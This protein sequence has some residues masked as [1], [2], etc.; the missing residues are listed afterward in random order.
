MALEAGCFGP[1]LSTGTWQE[2]M[3][4]QL[5]EATMQLRKFCK[6]QKLACYIQPFKTC[7]LSLSTL[8]STPYLKAKAHRQ[9]IVSLW[10]ETVMQR[11]TTLS[12]STEATM[13]HMCIDGF[14]KSWQICKAVK[15]RGS[16][17]LEGNESEQLDQ[18]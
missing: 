4:P 11:C 3:L 9:A 18:A 8:S 7:T 6:E 16:I 5:R 2:R 12:P 13:A 15:A 10:L 14:N 17:F 1:A